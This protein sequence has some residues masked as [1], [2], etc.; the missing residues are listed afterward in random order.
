MFCLFS[1]NDSV[2]GHITVEVGWAKLAAMAHDRKH[3]PQAL[4]TCRL[5]VRFK[6]Q[7]YAPP[8]CAVLQLDTPLAPEDDQ[9]AVETGQGDWLELDSAE[10]K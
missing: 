5:R 7:G 1:K 4:S 3:D 10:I 6:A 2:R 8:P 9:H